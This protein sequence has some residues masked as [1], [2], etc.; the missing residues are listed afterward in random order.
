MLK[1]TSRRRMVSLGETVDVLPNVIRLLDDFKRHITCWL[2]HIELKNKVIV[3]IMRYI[4]S[5]A[6]AQVVGLGN[7]G[8]S[9]TRHSVGM[10]VLAAMSERLGVS[11]GWRNDKLVSGE[12]IVSVIG[13]TQLVLLR[14]SLLMNINGVSVAKAGE[15]DRL[16]QIFCVLQCD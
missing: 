15:D 10:A 5:R 7:P 1:S 12:V 13:D 4:S 3:T 9:G 6:L 14:P 8:M 16:Q 2:L 11:S